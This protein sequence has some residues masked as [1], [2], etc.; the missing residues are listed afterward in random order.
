MARRRDE[1]IEEE[2]AALAQARQEAKERKEIRDKEQHSQQPSQ[3]PTQAASSSSSS[4]TK[5]QLALLTTA[6]ACQE[7]DETIAKLEAEY[8]RYLMKKTE[9]EELANALRRVTLT[10]PYSYLNPK[11]NPNPDPNNI[12]DLDPDQILPTLTNNLSNTP[13]NPLSK[14]SNP[15]STPSNPLSTP[16]NP[17]E[18]IGRCARPLLRKAPDDRAAESGSD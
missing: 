10:L 18:R 7:K 8:E 2:L 12:P 17:Q 5:V 13:S 1:G 16:S 9:S 11:H 14:P 3:T 6:L 15:L 4:S